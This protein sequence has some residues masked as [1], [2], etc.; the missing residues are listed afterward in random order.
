MQIW[1]FSLFYKLSPNTWTYRKSK[2][3][4]N[5]KFSYT[6]LQ[7]LLSNSSKTDNPPTFVW[8]L[9]DFSLALMGII[10]FISSDSSKNF[11]HFNNLLTL[12]Q[13]FFTILADMVTVFN[14]KSFAEHSMIQPQW[15]NPEQLGKCGQS[16]S[17]L[18][19]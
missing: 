12:A 9:S 7:V 18:Q 6:L 17:F 16:I 10:G 14:K 15:T 13:F 8:T 1:E 19:T 11:I 3:Y 4:N 2:I 5:R